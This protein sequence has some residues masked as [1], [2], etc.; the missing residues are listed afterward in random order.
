MTLPVSEVH[1][2]DVYRC[3]GW[4]VVHGTPE[5]GTAEIAGNLYVANVVGGTVSMSCEN[6]PVDWAGT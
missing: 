2:D 3:E 1:P 6:G 5:V 4:G